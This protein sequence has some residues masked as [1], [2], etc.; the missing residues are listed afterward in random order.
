MRRRR[1]NAVEQN[2][3]KGVRTASLKTLDSRE[4]PQAP[5]E[6]DEKPTLMNLPA[7][8]RKIIFYYAL[9]EPEPLIAYLARPTIKRPPEKCLKHQPPP[10]PNPLQPLMPHF[11]RL[12]SGASTLPV[13]YQRPLATTR[14]CGCNKY[15]TSTLRRLVAYPGKPALLNVSFHIRQEASPLFWRE[16]TFIFN[17]D[18]DYH[19]SAHELRSPVQQWISLTNIAE[20]TRNRYKVLLEFTMSPLRGDYHRVASIKVS[21]IEGWKIALEFGGALQDECTCAFTKKANDVTDWSSG[22][23][24]MQT[25]VGHFAAYVQEEVYRSLT[26]ASRLRGKTLECSSC[27]KLYPSQKVWR[28]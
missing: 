8:L 21:R 6:S 14:A 17:L 19:D 11:A 22:V 12:D 20:Q 9:V 25:A 13:Q 24:M 5:Y 26:L 27:R 23:G 7:E 16:N 2:I 28:R 18:R 1:S 15:L 3:S 10:E 4:V